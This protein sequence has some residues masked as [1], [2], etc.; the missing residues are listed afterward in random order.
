MA[1]VFCLPFSAPNFWIFHSSWKAVD[2]GFLGEPLFKDS[3]NGRRTSTWTSLSIR[4]LHEI[5]WNIKLST[6]ILLESSSLSFPR[7][8]SFVILFIIPQSSSSTPT[9]HWNNVAMRWSRKT[10]N[11]G[12][13][14]KH[15]LLAHIHISR[16]CCHAPT[17][18][19]EQTKKKLC[20]EKLL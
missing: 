15:T 3:W 19:D 20:R 12:G 1:I 4:I 7:R 8:N 10:S 17:R 9:N 6:R 13:F 16:F 11:F 14:F 2:E 5:F 18:I